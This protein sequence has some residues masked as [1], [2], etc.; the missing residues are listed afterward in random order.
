MEDENGWGVR[1]KVMDFGRKAGGFIIRFINK[2]VFDFA[3]DVL[4]FVRNLRLTVVFR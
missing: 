3:H 4:P 1:A 2:Y